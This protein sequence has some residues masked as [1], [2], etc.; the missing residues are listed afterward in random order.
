MKTCIYNHSYTAIT[1]E[2]NTGISHTAELI[3]L[4]FQ[5]Y[6]HFDRLAIIS[7]VQRSNR[8]EIFH[9]ARARNV[10]F[11]QS[12]RVPHSKILP[13]TPFATISGFDDVNAQRVYTVLL[14]RLAAN[15][16]PNMATW[17]G[18]N[19]DGGTRQTEGRDV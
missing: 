19:R 5:I 8:R 13:I 9:Q 10:L 1:T 15:N 6:K 12:V 16:S 14:T 11:R 3:Q 17:Y 7:A 2:Y 4:F 18:E